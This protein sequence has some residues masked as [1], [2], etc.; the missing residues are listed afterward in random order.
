L[1]DPSNE[2]YPFIYELWNRTERMVVGYYALL[3][4]DSAIVSANRKAAKTGSS[5]QMNSHTVCQVHFVAR[6]DA[7][8]FIEFGHIRERSVHTIFCG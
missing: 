4:P 5:P 6:L 7:K 3:Y 1:G 2:G 8:S